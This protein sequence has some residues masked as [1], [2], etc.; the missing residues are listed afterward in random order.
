M[1]GFLGRCAFAGEA[2]DARA[3]GATFVGQATFNGGVAVTSW[4]R[5]DVAGLL[6]RGLALATNVSPT[7]EAHPVV[8]IFGEQTC[9]AVRVGGYPFPVGRDYLELC[10]AVPFVR[11]VQG[12]YLHTFIP[13]MYATYLPA[14][15]NGNAH[16]GFSKRLARISW[17]GSLYVVTTTA[18]V[19]LL[20]TE[21]EPVKGSDPAAVPPNFAAM[22]E[23]FSLPVV[24][25]KQ[26]GSYVAS[27]FEWDFDTAVVRAADAVVSIDEPFLEGL[28]PR[29][30]PDAP[31]GSFD[32]RGMVWRL[33]WPSPPRWG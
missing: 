19:L 21:V 8:F 29:R 24:G 13:R 1:D 7:P 28:T 26:D 2:V 22:R 3:A 15:W 11:H 17:D 32:V 27:Y 10:V 25:R 20:H 23:M 30:C 12:R 33:S 4:P 14:V 9:G 6:P 16:Y 18:G 5:G 31:S